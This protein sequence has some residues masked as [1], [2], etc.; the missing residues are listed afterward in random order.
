MN[1]VE[2]FIHHVHPYKVPYMQKGGDQ[3]P[4]HRSHSVPDLSKD[5]S[6]TLRGA[7]RVIPTTPQAAEVTAVTTSKASQQ[8]VKGK[9]FCCFH[10]SSHPNIV[11]I[12]PI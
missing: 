3:L 11:L 5:G 1:L 8:D 4:I 12:K 6:I 9:L 10:L 7:F 2:E